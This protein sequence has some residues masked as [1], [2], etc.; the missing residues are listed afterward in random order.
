MKT[1]ARNLSAIL[2]VLAFTLAFGTARADLVGGAYLATNNITIWNTSFNGGIPPQFT[3]I[4]SASL[5]GANS[6]QGQPSPGGGATYTVLSEIFTPTIGFTLTG[7]GVIATHSVAGTGLSLHLFDV[8]T[9][10]TPLTGG[11]NASG[12][13]YTNG[14]DL[15]GN[16]AGLTF[17]SVGSNP[18]QEFFA[19]TNGPTSN[20][21]I[22]LATNHTYALEIWTPV[23]TGGAF[24]WLRTPNASILDP[25]GQGMGSHD[26]SFSVARQTVTSLGLASGAPR[27]FTLALYSTNYV[28]T[29]PVTNAVTTLLNPVPASYGPPTVWPYM[30]GIAVSTEAGN[31]NTDESF[32]GKIVM[33]QTFL[34]TRDFNLR[35]FYFAVQGTTNSG[36]YVLVLNDLGAAS[37]TNYGATLNLAAFTNLL[38]HPAALFPQYWSFSPVGLTNKTIVKFKF[39]GGDQ[40]TLTNGHSYFLGF[41]YASGSNDMILERT[42]SGSSYANGSAFKGSTTSVTNNGFAATT[43]DLL[44]AVDVLNPNLVISVTNAPLASSWPTLAGAANGGEPFI[45]TLANPS[46]AEPGDGNGVQEGLANGRAISMGFIATNDFNLGAIALTQRGLGS[47]NCLFTLAVYDVTNTFFSQGTNGS[48]NKWP[49]NYLPSIDTSP[50]GVPVFGTNVDFYY[51]SDNGLN[52]VGLGTGDQILI[53][54]LDQPANQVLLHSNHVYLVEIT[55]DTFGQNANTDA[56]FQ[57][58]RDLGQDQFQIDLFPNLGD[59]IQLLGRRTNSASGNVA[60]FIIPRALSRNFTDPEN[61][62]G[63]VAGQPRD[64][65][66]AVYAVTP[67]AAPTSITISSVTRNGNNVA[68]IWSPI[69]AGTYSYTVWRKVN[70]TDV[71]WTL[72]QSGISGGTYTDTSATT[73]TG[74]YR[75]SSP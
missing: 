39:S 8:T 26:S 54:T 31:V 11:L 38:S 17:D 37:T 1:I 32:A 47:S 9:N 60:S 67:P 27:T 28:N 33:G 71:S 57:W 19:L 44:M 41:A 20:D 7:I 36:K 34:A 30:A 3:S 2:G 70:L 68:L 15:L 61:I 12:T 10:L 45:Q 48:I 46:S 50:L 56:L 58:I 29:G 4:S 75:V 6:P 52:G 69:P 18:E 22:F 14:P 72:V 66:M 43:R 74:F 25:S 16:G 21:Q 35:N 64:F 40:V 51:T 5:S 63:Q 42:T 55:A 59:G 65:V 23:S 62:A 73:P 13:T 53:L 24:I 49:F